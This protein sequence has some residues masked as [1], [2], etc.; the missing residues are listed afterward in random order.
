MY[1]PNCRASAPPDAESCRACGYPLLPARAAPPSPY[2]AAVG[3][4]VRLADSGQPL[5]G[6]DRR[7]LVRSSLATLLGLLFAMVLPVL[8]ALAL[9]RAGISPASVGAL[10][11]LVGGSMGA[12]VELLH[13][14]WGTGLCGMLIWA[15]LIGLV[16]LGLP[17]ALS[18]LLGAGWLLLSRLRSLGQP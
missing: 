6:K 3:A 11:L 1:C 8:L 14:R 18:L 4:T 15:G 7:G 17:V 13:G 5:P 10:L 12:M 16:A 2:R 9:V